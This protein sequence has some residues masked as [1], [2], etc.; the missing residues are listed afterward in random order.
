MIK[1]GWK[2]FSDKNGGTWFY[3]HIVSHYIQLENEYKKIF[4]KFVKEDF[5]ILDL[6][7]GRLFYRDFIRKYA[8][9]YKS[10]DFEKTHKDLD[11]IGTS[12]RTGL[13]KE[14]FD[15]VFCSQVLEHV[16]D[17]KESF[18]EINRILR[19]DG[20]A[21]ISTPFLMYLHNEPYDFYRYTKHA[22]KKFAIE[23][24]F[25]IIK[26]KEVGGLFGFIGSIFA[27]FSIGLFWRI[28]ILNWIIYWIN[29]VLQHLFLFLDEITAN[30]KVFPSNYLLVVRKI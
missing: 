14:S 1:K 3:F 29:F 20:I 4:S 18:E 24:N 16:P 10:I 6:G 17:P 8:S 27:M 25:E 13:K 7:A 5:N 11:Y 2:S 22:L 26:L 12:S 28:P 30:A 19:K 15:V 9:N 21:I 23:S